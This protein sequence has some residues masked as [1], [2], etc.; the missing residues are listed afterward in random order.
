M[1]EALP[2]D[3]SFEQALEVLD[4]IVRDL[5]DGQTGLEESLQ[6]YETGV[7]LLNRCYGQLRL[8]EQRIVELSG[9]DEQGKPIIQ[10]FQHASAEADKADANR[11]RKRIDDP[12]KLF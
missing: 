5:E 10:V 3:L 12:E 4:K 1:S 9:V 6:R 8:A 2:D 7:R 11:R